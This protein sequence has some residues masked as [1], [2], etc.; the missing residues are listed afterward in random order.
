MTRSEASYASSRRDGPKTLHPRP[1]ETKL[2]SK[3][4]RILN[5]LHRE[6]SCSRF[7]LARR[8]NIN[9]SMVGLYVKQFIEQGLLIEEKRRESRRGRHPVPLRLNSKYGYFAGID[10]EFSGARGVITDFAGDVVSQREI[11]FEPYADAHTT[12]ARLIELAREL[13][14]ECHGKRIFSLGV[15]APGIVDVP[16]GI[17]RLYDLIPGF[18]NIPIVE[19]LQSEVSIPVYLDDS[20]RAITRAEMMRGAGR[21]ASHVVCLTARSGL[22]MG[23]VIDGRIQSGV[24]GLAGRIGSTVLLVG[25]RPQR[26]IDLASG[27]ALIRQARQALSEA[28]RTDARAALLAAGNVRLAPIAQAAEEGDSVLADVLLEGGR[29]LGILAANLVNLLAPERLILTG[30]V[31]SVSPILKRRFTETFERH[32]IPSVAERLTVVDGQLSQFAGALGMAQIGF[33]QAFPEEEEV[34]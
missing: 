24:A 29:C 9:A 34:A 6:G 12:V 32:A 30:E 20:F 33:S 27:V 16:A 8:L 7:H 23:L 31:L 10:Y 19:R 26:A 17:V 21:G 14:H 11:R 5:L 25:D 4:H 2:Y 22:G 15:A 18:E 1:R 13:V 3:L 28:P